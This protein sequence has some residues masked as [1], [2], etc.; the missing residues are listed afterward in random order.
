MR[1]SLCTARGNGTRVM[2]VRKRGTRYENWSQVR[3][4]GGKS[5]LEGGWVVK[6][7]LFDQRWAAML[8]AQICGRS[9]IENFLLRSAFIILCPY[10]GLPSKPHFI[11]GSAQRL[12]HMSCRAT[13][14]RGP[15]HTLRLT[16]T[17]PYR[18]E[19]VRW[20]QKFV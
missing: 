5:R 9:L 1:F 20:K 6:S 7:T 11:L 19:L 2:Q 18:V 13:A 14:Q 15:L 3:S 10:L 12:A 16:R 17:G 4:K 8:R